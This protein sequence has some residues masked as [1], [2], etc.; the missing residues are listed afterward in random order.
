MYLK[1]MEG[2]PMSSPLLSETGTPDKTDFS[3]LL[4]EEKS[5]RRLSA[6]VALRLRLSVSPVV[7]PS[8][9]LS[10]RATE[11]PWAVDRRGQSGSCHG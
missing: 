11:R 7:W 6:R 10:G 1:G 9:Q 3:R 2:M 5:H 8:G 4:M